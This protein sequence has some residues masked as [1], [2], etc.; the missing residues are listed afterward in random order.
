MLER[1]KARRVA[2]SIG[3][4]VAT[5]RFLPGW[6]ETIEGEIVQGGTLLIEYTL[7]RT[8][9]AFSDA[10]GVTPPNVEAHVRFAPGG[11]HLMASV[12]AACEVPIPGDATSLEL[13]FHGTDRD[14][15][16][17]WDS[18]FGENYRFRVWPRAGGAA[19]TEP[20]APESP[21]RRRKPAA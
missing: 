15:T 19:S 9:E 3:G 2:P 7:G 12:S 11:Q 21:A 6:Q 14:R 4:L 5:L 10:G 17:A 16:T 8:I 18:R 1:P 13:W 20:L